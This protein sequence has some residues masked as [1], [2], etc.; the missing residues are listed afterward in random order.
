M[1]DKEYRYLTLTFDRP[2]FKRMTRDLKTGKIN[3]VIVKSLDRLGRGSH[4]EDIIEEHF[5]IPKIRFIAIAE[6]V[7]TIEGID[8]LIDILHVMNGLVPKITSRKVRQVKRENAKNGMFMNSQAPYGFKKSPDNKHFL[9]EDEEAAAIVRRL[10]TEFANGDSAREIGARLTAEGKDSPRFYHYAK[11]GK[12]VPYKNAKNTWGSATVLKLMRNEAYIGNLIQGKREVISIK[13]KKVRLVDEEDWIRKEETHDPIVSRD[14][15]DRVNARLRTKS[16]ARKAV[17]RNTRFDK[18]AHIGLFSTIL[19]C[20]D[21]GSALAYMRKKLK[22]SEKGVYRCT[23]YNNNG[24][25]ACTPHYIE[26]PDLCAFILNDI[27]RYATLAVNERK[28]LASRLMQSQRQNQNDEASILRNSIN[29]AESRLAEI[30]A[31]QK[32]LFEEK[33]AGNIPQS[34]FNNLIKGYDTEQAEIEEK[35]PRLRRELESIQESVSEIENWLNLIES[36]TELETLDRPTVVG[37]I[38]SVIVS[39]RVKVKGQKHSQNLEVKYRIIGNLPNNAKED[40][41][42]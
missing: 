8:Y 41:V 29:A 26:E 16:I 18:N 13:T 36:Y 32:A 6:S 9:I 1:F 5:N 11:L 14:L 22:T 35:L 27:T 10:F 24:G 15:W 12:P 30:A 38:E 3:M 33:F 21:C 7:D 2:D 34:V 42:S 39:E 20:A 25:S 31:R 40:A 37:L 19:R 4:T 17:P 23:R 28:Q